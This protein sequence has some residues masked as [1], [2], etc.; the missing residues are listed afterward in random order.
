MNSG[1]CFTEPNAGKT[2]R[3]SG[4]DRSEL[5]S[6]QQKKSSFSKFVGKD[7]RSKTDGIINFKQKASPRKNMMSAKTSYQSPDTKAS[8]LFT[9]K[10]RSSR[11]N[12]DSAHDKIT[13]INEDLLH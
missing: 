4:D 9:N 6:F 13:D 3:G 7:L 1:I 10:F 5:L 2:V 11:T 8:L 12:K